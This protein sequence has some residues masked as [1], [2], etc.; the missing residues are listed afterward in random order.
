MIDSIVEIPISTYWLI[1]TFFYK[2]NSKL[3]INACSYQEFKDIVPKFI[4]CDISFVVLFLHSFSFLKWNK[5]HS[6]VIPDYVTIKKFE[7]IFSFIT[8]L[9]NVD[10]L[11]IKESVP[12]LATDK[13]VSFDFTPSVNIFK[14]G[15]RIIQRLS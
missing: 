3:D 12:L 11:T 7:K 15:N 8:T 6:H 14:I 4:H 10:F 13:E 1:H 2:K 5:D 9:N